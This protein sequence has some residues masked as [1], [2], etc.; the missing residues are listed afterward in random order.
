MLGDIGTGQDIAGTAE[1]H[2]AVRTG[3]F[4]IAEGSEQAY[5]AVGHIA[6]ADTG[7]LEELVGQP[8]HMV[9]DNRNKVNIAAL[10]YLAEVAGP[11]L[12]SL[13]QGFPP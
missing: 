4:G 2:I 7:T 8:A 6:A 11:D 3:L 10:A 5:M 1:V 9:A 12:G 13:E